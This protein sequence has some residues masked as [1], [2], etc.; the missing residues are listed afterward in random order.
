MQTESLMEPHVPLQNAAKIEIKEL[1]KQVQRLLR[2]AKCSPRLWDYC[3]T[4]V[5]EIRTRTSFGTRNSKKRTGYEVVTGN[6]PD[7]S[8]WAEFCWYQPVWYLD[9]VTWPDDRRNLLDGWGYLTGLDR[10]CVTSYCFLVV[11]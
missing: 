3:L 9:E 4:S 10:P 5:S 7:I 8:E 6:T 11:K 1:K 2:K